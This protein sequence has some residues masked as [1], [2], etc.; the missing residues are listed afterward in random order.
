MNEEASRETVQTEK[1]KTTAKNCLGE[2]LSHCFEKLYGP[3]KA[4]IQECESVNFDVKE[5]FR[6]GL[7]P[8]YH[9]EKHAMGL[10]DVVRVR[11]DAANIP[12]YLSETKRL[13]DGRNKGTVRIN[14]YHVGKKSSFR[15]RANTSSSE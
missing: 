14:V 7:S 13:F 3:I 12:W 5:R 11:R 2:K 1:L 8:A 10:A 15:R 4:I 6:N 9:Y